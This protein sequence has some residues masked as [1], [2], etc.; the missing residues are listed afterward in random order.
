M[1]VFH[2]KVVKDLSE[3]AINEDQLQFMLQV[4]QAHRCR[5]PDFNKE[6]LIKLTITH[7]VGG[8]AIADCGNW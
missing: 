6:T 1:F 8:I 4:I 3:R 2:V 5:L 7:S